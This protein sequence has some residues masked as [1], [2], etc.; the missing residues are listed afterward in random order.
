MSRLIKLLEKT[1]FQTSSP[2][3]FGAASRRDEA[4][5]SIALIGRTTDRELTKRRKLR[6]AE[7][8]AFMV[9]MG[10]W[11]ASQVDSIGEALESR[12]WGIRVGGLNGEQVSLLKEKGCDFVVF[13]AEDTAAE[14]LNEDELGK[15]VAVGP[16]LS[17]DQARAIQDLAID[18]VLFSQ[19]K[20]IL[21]LTVAKLMDVQQVLA[22]VNKPF[23]MEAPSNLESPELESLRNAGIT[24]L[25]VELSSVKA[26]SEMRQ[27]IAALPGQ[28]S[29]GTGRYAA[30]PQPTL[31]I[32]PPG[33]EEDD[34]FWR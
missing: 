31:E 18:G 29:E 19:Q 26:I 16:D 27:A 5:L 15:L 7:V 10:S 20:E 14:V 3:G 28:R 2:I 1:G 8:D 25:V 21:P 6:D 12:L 9:S 24:G 4:P 13:D 34:E 33:S 32:A 30:V 17:E 11:E 22:L 23:V